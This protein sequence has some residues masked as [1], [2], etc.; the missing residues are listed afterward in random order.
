MNLW[1]GYDTESVHDAIWVLLPDFAD[2]E[3][4][5][6]RACA[7]S[8]RVCELEALEAVAALRLLSHHIQD[9]VH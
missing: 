9:Q 7:S 5:H 2:E 3:C 4:A 6:P 1:W 8:Q